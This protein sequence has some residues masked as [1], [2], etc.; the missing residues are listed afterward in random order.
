MPFDGTNFSLRPEKPARPAPSDN[1]VTILIII[2]S[3]SLLFMP[4]S[5]AGLIDIVWYLRGH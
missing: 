2:I 1:V 5:M 4:V 3:F